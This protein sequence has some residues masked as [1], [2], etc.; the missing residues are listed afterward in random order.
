MP[1]ST[2]RSRA[3]SRGPRKKNTRTIAPTIVA[4][5]AI[6]WRAVIIA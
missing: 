1:S 6:A 4:A 5:T 2:R 3:Y